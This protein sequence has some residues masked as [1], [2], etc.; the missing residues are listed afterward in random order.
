MHLEAEEIGEE[1]APQLEVGLEVLGHEA[2]VHEGLRLQ[3]VQQSRGCRRQRAGGAQGTA[4]LVD[5]RR[6]LCP[7][8]LLGSG[9][10]VW[11]GSGLG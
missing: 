6:I 4:P 2:A 10:G 3:L 5:S 7:P 1:H 11:S 9:P 8:A